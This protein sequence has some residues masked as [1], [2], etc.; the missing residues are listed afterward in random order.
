MSLLVVW[1]DERP[2][3]ALRRTEDPEAI[4]DALHEI[5]CRFEHRPV[6]PEVRP[7]SDQD[8]VLEAYRDEVDELIGEYGFG[9]VDVAVSYP[10]DEADWAA[11]AAQLRAQFAS[12]HTH[13]DAEVRYVVRGS[14]VFYL[15]AGGMVAALRA[16]AGDLIAVP[17][18]TAHWFDMG[19]RPDF[20]TIRFFPD[21]QG[22]VGHPTGSDIARRIPDADAV[23]ALAP[24]HS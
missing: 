23:R 10:S 19:R 22:W 8:A 16:M 9:S 18:K 20:T 17:A 7:D 13:G 6:R 11:Q 14:G 21:A 4:V 15:H 1:P 2:A 5:G 12:E 3:T 24:E